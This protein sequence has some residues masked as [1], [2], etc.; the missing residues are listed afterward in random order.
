MTKGE[1]DKLRSWYRHRHLWVAGLIAVISL[2]TFA[3]VADEVAETEARR[4]DRQIL[5]AMRR[6]GQPGEP[7]GPPWVEAT[8]HG[9]SFLADYKFLLPGVPLV[10]GG[11]FLLRWRADAVYF[12]SV[13]ASGFGAAMLMKMLFGR[14]RPPE[15]Y[16]LAHTSTE[17]FPSAHAMV[18]AC[19]Y[20]SLALIFSRRLD[21]RG[22]AVLVI[23][24]GLVISGLI[25][26]TRV[27][28][29]V[30]WPSDVLAGW[31]AGLA[32]A[33][34][35]WIAMSIWRVRRSPSA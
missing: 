30:H 20:V 8:A 21:R 19:V 35:G 10:V 2:W 15:I 5:Q 17:S 4:F 18:S 25:G 22:S 12:I 14:S 9:I 26:A 7:I 28:L 6:P 34:A 23:A 16:R 27:Y 33:L 1:S 32:W 29:G 13:S 24:T 31:A 3:S 11:L